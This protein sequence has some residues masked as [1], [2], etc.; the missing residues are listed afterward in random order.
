VTGRRFKA[1][2]SARPLPVSGLGKRPG[3]RRLR[4][5]LPT[6][7]CLRWDGGAHQTPSGTS[8]LKKV[9]N[10]DPIWAA[11]DRL[12]TPENG[13]PNQ[14]LAIKLSRIALA[15]PHRNQDALIARVMALP[16]P[17][18]SKREL[19][20]AMAMDGQA[21][22]ARHVMQAIDD[23]IADAGTDPN[24]TWQKRQITWEI[25][26]WLELLPYTDNPDSVIEGL[27]KVKA[28]Y[29]QGWAQRWERVLTAVAVMPGLEGEALLE[30]P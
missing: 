5:T 27:A 6:P 10:A 4:Q 28:F 19:L 22:D 24:K 7:F 2:P 29:Q 15:M 9:A 18:T 16:Q 26:P 3:S 8:P 12:A 13:K 25:E 14:E 11:I 30:T 23:W 1:A 20:A 21:L 17:L